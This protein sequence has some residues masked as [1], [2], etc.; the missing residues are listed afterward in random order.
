MPDQLRVVELTGDTFPLLEDLFGP[1]GAVAGCWCMWFRWSAREYR[2]NA[3]EPNRRAL[4][5]L[6]EQGEPVGLLAVDDTDTARGWVAVSPRLVQVRLARS[7]VSAPPDPD[8]DLTGVWCVTCLFIRAGWRRRGIGGLLVPAAVEY[9]A[10]RGARVV[11]AYPVETRP[12][13]R[14]GTGELY[15]GTVSLFVKAGFE[16]VARRGERRALV[17]CTV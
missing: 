6:A 8:E 11:E 3:G 2:D 13:R 5:S 7:T 9:A 1:N 4:R 12:G 15:H 16:I 14:Y 17:R 10:R